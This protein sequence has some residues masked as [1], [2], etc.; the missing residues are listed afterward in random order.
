VCSNF[1]RIDAFARTVGIFGTSA[2]AGGESG[3]YARGVVGGFGDTA[4]IDAIARLIWIAGWA[5]SR[6]AGNSE[7][8]VV[9]ETPASVRRG[10]L[11]PRL[12]T[13][14]DNPA[15]ITEILT[16]RIATNYANITPF[17][18]PSVVSTGKSL[19]SHY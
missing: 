9:P 6:R 11:T 14:G 13:I 19:A 10:N 17:V 3:E 15:R 4:T 5:R 7:N 8:L 18:C 16:K 12:P 1:S 2:F